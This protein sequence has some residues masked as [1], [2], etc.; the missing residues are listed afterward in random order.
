MTRVCL[1]EGVEAA[2]RGLRLFL[3]SRTLCS[4]ITS[5]EQGRQGNGRCFPPPFYFSCLWDS[6]RREQG[7]EQKGSSAALQFPPLETL[8]RRGG[9][10]PCGGS[11]RRGDPLRSQRPVGSA[12]VLQPFHEQ[13][14]LHR[15]EKQRSIFPFSSSLSLA[16]Q[17]PI[18]LGAKQNAR[19]RMFAVAR[20]AAVADLLAVSRSLLFCF[21][22][23]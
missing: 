22:H 16:G 21:F 20:C 13:G 17:R 7:S 18:Q 15:L 19:K 11:C 1:G 10:L 5:P 3:C 4:G 14:E 12:G 6:A 9:A 2:K 8:A 23:R